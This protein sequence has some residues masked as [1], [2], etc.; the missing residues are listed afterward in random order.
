[1]YNPF[2]VNKEC[3]AHVIAFQCWTLSMTEVRL[4]YPN[5]DHA[6]VEVYMDCM[7]EDCD[8]DLGGLS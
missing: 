7:T 6:L 8:W 5:A 2:H 3:E 1:M 4:Y